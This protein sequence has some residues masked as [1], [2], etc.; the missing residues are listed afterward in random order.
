[1][2]VSHK[3]SLPTASLLVSGHPVESNQYLKRLCKC[4]KLKSIIFYLQNVE[5]CSKGLRMHWSII[6]K[7]GELQQLLQS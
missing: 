6:W 4:S 1:M 7:R 5:K 3:H 2:D